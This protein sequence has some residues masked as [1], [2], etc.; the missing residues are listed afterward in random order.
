MTFFPRGAR[1]ALPALVA[2]LFGAST[3]SAASLPPPYNS[4]TT[5][6]AQWNQE[7]VQWA[8]TTLAENTGY[9]KPILGR[10]FS[11]PRIRFLQKTP[12]NT[13]CGE[14][15][16]SESATYCPADQTIYVDV[17]FLQNQE[18]TF[19]PHAAQLIV[20]HEYGHHIQNLQ[21][22]PQMGMQTELQADC[23]AGAA[24]ASQA[25][26][27][28]LDLNA[29]G[30]TLVYTTEAAGDPSWPTKVTARPTSG[31]AR[32][33]TAYRICRAASSPAT[34]T[35]IHRSSPEASPLKQAGSAAR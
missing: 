33:S 14:V 30:L 15:D 27:E 35:T 2:A 16:N 18:A 34:A 20:D 9:W 4:R 13:G 26:A 25:V 17:F 10:K 31:W 7:W 5:T 22:L 6:T 23:L 8:E 29:L 1:L 24:I 12:I 32:C 19:G 3:A 11:P 28:T 21:G